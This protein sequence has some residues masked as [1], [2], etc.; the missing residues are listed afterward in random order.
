MTQVA[1]RYGIFTGIG[2]TVYSILLY[3]MGLEVFSNFWLYLLLYPVIIFLMV[4]L[5]IRIRN[6]I[7]GGAMTFKEGFSSSFLIGS[8]SS[9]IPL[10][11]GLLLFNVIDPD[12]KTEMPE[13]I[14][15]KTEQMMTDWG[16]PQS[17]IDETLAQQVE[18][19][20]K[21]FTMVGQL[22]GFLKGLIFYAVVSALIGLI[23]KRKPGAQT[24]GDVA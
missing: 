14:I 23:V 24:A 13:I 20:P 4:F 3:A 16:A 21:G 19:I 6:K 9:V 15:S 17:S 12:L 8:V 22:T 10:L 2:L 18:E 7:L 1:I 11:W 5:S